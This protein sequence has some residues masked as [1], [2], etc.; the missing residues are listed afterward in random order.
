MKIARSLIAGAGVGLFLC[1]IARGDD[2]QIPNVRNRSGPVIVKRVI[3]VRGGVG[4]VIYVRPA[5][6][7]HSALPANRSR[8]SA[9]GVQSHWRSFETSGSTDNY[10]HAARTLKT[11]HSVET[12]QLD[13]QADA[14]N[15][16]NK[17]AGRKPEPKQPDTKQP[18]AKQQDAKQREANESEDAGGLDR[19]TVQAQKEQAIQPAEPGGIQPK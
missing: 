13:Q 4:R 1:A 3:V 7:L 12:S 11:G 8:Y 19:L 5:Y 15:R 16:D 17:S 10:N 2:D 9:T 6:S 18:D 14:D